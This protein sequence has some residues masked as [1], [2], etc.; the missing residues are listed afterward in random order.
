MNLTR[1]ESVL[2]EAVRNPRV[3][4]TGWFLRDRDNAVKRL[5]DDITVNHI[6]D[7]KLI[8]IAMTGPSRRELPE[9][10]NA[11]AEAAQ[12]DS[13]ETANRST[14]DQIRQLQGQRTNLVETRDR[15]RT[16]KAK[17]L[18]EAEVPGMRDKRERG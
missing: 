5:L 1:S 14:Q 17:L 8:R 16:E 10:V 2:Q 13:L 7:T 4:N 12:A 15:M 11:V 18:R 3:R 6:P 9:I